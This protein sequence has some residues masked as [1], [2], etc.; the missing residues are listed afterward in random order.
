MTN[1]DILIKL[2][3]I[4]HDINPDIDVTEDLALIQSGE[5][6]S[7]EIINYLTQ[8]E[9]VFNL[10]ITMEQLQEE[11]LGI[12]GNMMNYITSQII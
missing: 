10:E 4:I 2:T 7:L 11:K 3:N 6:D 8:I 1:K 9:E 5:M 12:V